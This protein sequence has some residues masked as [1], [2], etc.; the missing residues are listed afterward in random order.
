MGGVQKT[1]GF[2]IL[3]SGWLCRPGDL[4]CEVEVGPGPCINYPFC[5]TN[6][7]KT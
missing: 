1:L 4:H 6:H 5:T 3:F 2:V 7:L